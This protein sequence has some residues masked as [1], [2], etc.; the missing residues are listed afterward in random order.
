MISTSASRAASVLGYVTMAWVVAP[1]IA[2]TIGGLLDQAFSFQAT[3]WALAVIGAGVALGAW[4]YLPE[5]NS[6]I[7]GK[8]PLLRFDAFA[9]LLAQPA[10][11]GYV[12]TI[13]FASV[14]FFAYLAAAPY[15]IITAR[16]YPPVVFG[17]WSVATALGYML[18]N[19]ISGRY[20][21][22]FGNDRMIRAGNLITLFGAF[23]MLTLALAGYDASR[24]PV[25]ADVRLHAWQRPRHAERHHGG[26]LARPAHHRSRRRPGGLPPDG[27]V[28]GN[29]ADRWRGPGR[30]DR[31]RLLRNRGRI[32]LRGTGPLAEP[33]AVR[34]PSR[35]R[36]D[37][38][39][40]GLNAP[41]PTVGHHDAACDVGEERSEARK[42][43]GP[44]ISSGFPLRFSGV[45]SRYISTTWGFVLASLFV[46]RCLD[47][48]GPIALTRTPSGP[49]SAASALVKPSTLCFEVV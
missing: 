40:P 3:F 41:V 19:F 26:D 43:A 34:P 22:R 2:P 17:L 21:Q 8:G 7:G 31:F 14:V 27:A 37:G 36:P 1:M 46:E 16:E 24:Q 23:A 29:L 44:K 32:R 42:I 49:S 10:Y 20:S 48:A 12:A 18:G 38:R 28:G 30:V 35:G 6:D 45:C 13:T 39:A 5:T 33:P 4:R 11:R 9:G 47:Q 25:R 15:V